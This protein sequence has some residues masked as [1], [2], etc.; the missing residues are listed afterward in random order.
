[1]TT[2]QNSTFQFS[3]DRPFGIYFHDYFVQAYTL[4]TGKNPD[5][6]AFIEGVT[7]LST[8][9]E[10]AIAFITYFAVIFGGQYLMKSFPVIKLKFI[11]QLHNLLLTLSSLALLILF[12]EQLIPILF[13]NGI[14]HS[15]CSHDAW[16]QRLELL[17]YLNYLVKYWELADTIFLVLRKKNLEFLHVYHHSMTMALCFSQLEGKTSVSWV[18]I[19]LNLLVHV[20][21][22]YYYFRAAGGARIWWKKYLTTMQ[23]VQFIIDLFFVYF[24]SYTYFTANYWDWMPN[25]GSCAG[26]E[27]AAIFGCSLLSS[28]LLLFIGFYKKTYNDKKGTTISK[29]KATAKV[30]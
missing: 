12:A 25:Y 6:F 10:V 4:A 14:F 23:I 15:V 13:R 9:Y 28:Y 27:S 21:M 3:I 24:C 18:P 17:Y 7:P 22:Y 19:T 20:F 5:N 26:S 8:R 1:M 30:E 2:L 11:F 29:G 16:T